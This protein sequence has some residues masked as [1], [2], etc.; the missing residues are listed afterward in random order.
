MAV[1][2][3]PPLSRVLD[4]LIDR[5]VSIKTYLVAFNAQS[6]AGTISVTA[7]EELMRQLASFAGGVRAAATVP[8]LL[9]YAK[10]QYADDRI[11]IVA[12]YDALLAR[13]DNALK[14]I[15]LNMPKSGGYVLKEQWAEDGSITQRQFTAADLKNLRDV[16]DTVIAAIE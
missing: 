10:A 15:S 14:W 5:T 4:R 2:I 6:A 11:D 3:R 12:E 7:I 16:V 1:P 13:V 9:A 8:G